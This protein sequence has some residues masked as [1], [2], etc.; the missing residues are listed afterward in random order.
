MFTRS[1]AFRLKHADTQSSSPLHREST[2]QHRSTINTSDSDTRRTGQRDR[3]THNLSDIETQYLRSV[4]GCEAPS[5]KQ[6]FF[7]D[8]KNW[9]QEIKSEQADREAAAKLIKDAY[10]REAAEL[11]LDDLP[12][13]S[14]PPGMENL[15]HLQTL[16]LRHTQIKD[17]DYLI[18]LMP[19]LE[20]VYLGGTQQIT[21]SLHTRHVRFDEHPQRNIKIIDRTE[22]E[23]PIRGH[24]SENSYHR[25][26]SAR[27]NSIGKAYSER[28]LNQFAENRTQ[29]E[30]SA[31]KLTQNNANLLAEIIGEEDEHT[32]KF[33]LYSNITSTH[34]HR[35]NQVNSAK[36]ERH[37]RLQLPQLDRRPQ[38][39]QHQEE[40]LP[41]RD[42]KNGR[43]RWTSKEQ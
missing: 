24:N 26:R 17:S 28:E 42:A 19:H 7:K 27:T 22:E 33:Y 5:P 20:N 4:T 13:S 39:Y 30:E 29:R 38:R 3:N 12:I 32:S 1:N 23:T 6:V 10:A 36:G 37:A 34:T 31:K 15:V 16:S 9:T 35:R 8:I 18:D 21:S 25:H 2:Q 40:S 11:V 14:L 41:P 43:N